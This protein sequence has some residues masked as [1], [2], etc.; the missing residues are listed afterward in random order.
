[1]YRRSCKSAQHV[2]FLAGGCIHAGRSL[3]Q[4]A[5]ESRFLRGI[6]SVLEFVP[7]DPHALR[8]F[9]PEL[10]SI[11]PDFQNLHDDVADQDLFARFP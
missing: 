1:M 3:V 8:R 9:D 11:A 5:G 4:P 7:E 6:G 2:C 10:H